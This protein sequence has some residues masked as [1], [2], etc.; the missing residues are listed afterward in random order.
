MAL[1][2]SG[3]LAL[4]D[5]QTEFGGSNPIGM[6]E[7]Y[8]GGGLVPSG[9]SGTYGAV[10]SSGALSIQNFYG[11]SNYIP[12][13]IEDLFSAWAYTGN[14]TSQTIT[15][16]INVSGSGGLVWIKGRNG[17]AAPD[18]LL[19]DTTRGATVSLLTNETIGNYTNANTLTS[20]TSSGFS[21]GDYVYVNNPSG[22][23][24]STYISWTFRKQ[25]KFF[26]IVTYTGNSTN[27][28]IAHNLGSVPGFIIVKRTDG[29][30]NWFAYHRSTGA[31]K[32]MRLNSTDLSQSTV[33]WNNTEPTS[34]VFS[35][36]GGGSFIN[37]YNQ[38]GIL[39]CV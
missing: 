10:P 29:D 25:P 35:L 36:G 33:A 20:F 32:Y 5:I 28:T 39:C 2:S 30:G 38:T 1:P 6:N 16:G 4:T 19:F 8:A 24:G 21:V 3:P 17:S 18:H 15:N 13:Y 12:V 14:G 37:D 27:R 31:G 11:T 22:T 7:Y 34:S 23:F 26:D 9:T